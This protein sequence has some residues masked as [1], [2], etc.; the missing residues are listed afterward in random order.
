MYVKVKK[1]IVLECQDLD[2]YDV[3]TEDV[4]VGENF[5]DVLAYLYQK[6]YNKEYNELSWYLEDGAKEF[7]Y[8]LEDKWLHN[9]IDTFDIY[10]N[11]EF[12]DFLN[13]HTK[14]EIDDDTLED[15]FYDFYSQCESQI[16]WMSQEELERFINA[17]GYSEI[18]VT[19]YCDGHYRS[20]E[21]DLRDYLEDVYTYDDE[22]L[23]E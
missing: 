7:V 13:S 17:L 6:K 10:H 3:V 8:D 20:R 9:D 18:V 19:A 22:E 2:T 15:V 4:T 12:L 1:D 14:V 5:D 21:L 16:S 23:F 11:E